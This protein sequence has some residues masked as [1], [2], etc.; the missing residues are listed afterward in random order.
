MIGP[1]RRRVGQRPQRRDRLGIADDGVE[2]LGRADGIGADRGFARQH[3]RV[4]AR[5]DGAG[6]VR[7]LG[8]RRPGLGAHRLEH[9]RR[10][11]H[12][13]AAIAGEAEDLLLHL[14]HLFER[15][16]EAEIAARHHHRVGGVDDFRQAARIA[17]GRSSLATIGRCGRP[18]A[19]AMARARAMSPATL[20]EAERDQVD[21]QRRGRIADRPRPSAVTPTSGSGTLGALMPLCSP[22]APPSTTRVAIDVAA[23]AFDHQLDAPVV[24]QQAIARPYRERQRRIAR[25]NH[26]RAADRVA[27]P[28]LQRLVARQQQ[29]AVTARATRSGSS[30][31]S[32]PAGSPLPSPGSLTPRESP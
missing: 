25:R 21:A 17:S 23:G 20:H 18:A 3:D 4:G 26:P 10:D 29:R 30:G 32:G 27:D 24:Q 6:R 28:D 7:H 11:D 16:L 14:R 22:S 13:H 9:L 12:R 5:V 8:A 31:R 1:F 19:A 15:H 2:H